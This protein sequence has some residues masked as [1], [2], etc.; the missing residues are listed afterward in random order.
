MHGNGM[1]SE[2]AN[3]W[4][5][6]RLYSVWHVKKLPVK[7]R[8]TGPSALFFVDIYVNVTPCV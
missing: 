6:R 4:Q 1:V 8:V 7:R 5:E 2:Q 3:G